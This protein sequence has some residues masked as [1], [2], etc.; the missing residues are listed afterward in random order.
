MTNNTIIK[1]IFRDSIRRGTGQALLEDKL[2]EQLFPAAKYKMCF[3]EELVK[4]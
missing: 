1:K 2:A 3:T 4:Y